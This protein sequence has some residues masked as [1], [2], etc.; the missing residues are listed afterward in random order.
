MRVLIG[1]VCHESNTFT[2]F[3][4]TKADFWTLYGDELLSDRWGKLD[5]RHGTPLD[6]TGRVR[7]LA[8]GDTY[9]GGIRQEW[10]RR[11]TIAVLN[12]RGIDVILSSMRLNILEPSPLYKLGLDP[13][14]YR[15]F[16]LKRG[17]LTAPLQAISERN[18][19]ALTPGATNCR[20]AE[21][22]FVRLNRPAY[23]LDL[24]A[25]WRPGECF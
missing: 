12:V 25:T 22:A 19:L 8:D 9:R 24:D 23:P 1:S 6:V 21:M 7:L 10:G 17:L 20:V 18:I 16:A 15:I 2:P 13:L 4:T 5:T 14:D 11:G 3:P